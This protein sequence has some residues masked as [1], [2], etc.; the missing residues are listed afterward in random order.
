MS[1]EFDYVENV[2][3]TRPKACSRTVFENLLHSDKVRSICEEIGR[4]EEQ[5]K[6]TSSIA[7]AVLCTAEEKRLKEA[8]GQKKRDLPAFTFFSTFDGKAR[9][10]ENA[11]LSGLAYLD[12][13]HVD[14]PEALWRQIEARTATE[15][16]ARS[17]LVHKTPSNHGLRIVFEMLG[18]DIEAEAARM[19]RAMGVENYDAVCKDATR[20]S[21]AV[22]MEYV[23]LYVP[24]KLWMRRSVVVDDNLPKRVDSGEASFRGI[25]YKDIIAEWWRHT[26]GEPV[27]GE[28]NT[29]LY[30]LAANLRAIC[31]NDQARLMEI[32]PRYGLYEHEMQQIV[33]SACKEV[34]KGISARMKSVL[35]AL[36]GEA[37]EVC[38][39]ELAEESVE[40]EQ[41]EPMYHQILAPL[42]DVLRNSLETV[43]EEMRL[44]AL[45][46]L[47]PLL[48]SY[49]DGVEVRYCDGKRMMLG[50]MAIVVGEQASGKSA[51]K[52]VVDLWLKA[53]R[54]EDAEARRVEDAWREKRKARKANEKAPEDPKQLIREVPVTI[55]CSALLRRLKNAQGHAL[56]S[57]GEELDT[58]R[59]TNGAGSW[60]AKY[61]IYR[62][63]FDRS[64]WGQDFNSDQA[65]SGMVPVAYNWSILGTYGALRK[66][67]CSDNIENGLSSRIMLAEM[68]DNRFAPIPKYT[69]LPEGT[70]EEVDAAVVRLK[71]T[72]GFIDTPR[73]RET[74]EQWS[75]EKC[76]EA[77]KALD[78][79]KDTYRK[80]AAVIGFRC[81]V[82]HHL[83]SEGEEESDKT[84]EFARMMA[85]YTLAEQIALFGSMLQQS[86]DNNA[87]TMQRRGRNSLIYDEL[88]DVF[89]AQDI[90]RLKGNVRKSTISMIAHRW[91]EMG[92]IMQ[93]GHG[94]WKKVQSSQVQVHN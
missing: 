19:A 27:V 57:F 33:A 40:V 16:L 78:D 77:A 50:G 3:D 25:M 87:D 58:L 85:D 55:S 70:E 15:V 18:A 46:A 56:Y 38:L 53:M 91:A 73:L 20:L 54:R 89:G 61:D 74:I 68:P 6:A 83:L 92:I 2:R 63:S 31:D 49:A 24:E 71:A 88:P 48:M 21:F 35:A 8:V 52:E 29:R 45:V 42:P 14:D 22:P 69:E 4:L 79:V 44:P 93:I 62:M 1:R 84:L 66:C 86:M 67:F 82:V 7:D 75:D 37:G 28:R 81:G 72:K 59:K 36:M 34:P 30:Q 51:C 64:M 94:R 17:V 39:S 10:I 60:S 43:P 41:S 26:G 32:M 47:M 90:A 80:R 13:D 23:L 9:K 65:E 12:I 76:Q 11:R 5:L